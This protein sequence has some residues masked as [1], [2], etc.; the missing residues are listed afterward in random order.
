MEKRQLNEVPKEPPEKKTM[1]SEKLKEEEMPSPK[2]TKF[3]RGAIDDAKSIFN[4]N[5]KTNSG[6]IL[7]GKIRISLN[8]STI[9]LTFPAFFKS[10]E[11]EK[12]LVKVKE[13]QP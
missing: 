7:I 4:S 10:N 9:S 3:G 12:S 5:K 8:C 6:I 2:K 11:M 13:K 1:E